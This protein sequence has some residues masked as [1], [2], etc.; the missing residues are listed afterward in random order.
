MEIFLLKI[1]ENE[2]LKFFHNANFHI[3]EEIMNQNTCKS[4]QIY[5]FDINFFVKLT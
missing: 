2:S 4:N 5:I 1:I 3:H